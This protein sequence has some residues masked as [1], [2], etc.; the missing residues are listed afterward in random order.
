MLHLLPQATS[1][2][3]KLFGITGLDIR[4]YRWSVVKETRQWRGD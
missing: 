2:A 4:P 3:S 1:W